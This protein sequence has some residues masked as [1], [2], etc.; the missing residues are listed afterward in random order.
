VAAIPAVREIRGQ[1]LAADGNGVEDIMGRLGVHTIP[2][3]AAEGDDRTA[4]FGYG[5]ATAKGSRF[6]LLRP[7]AR[8]HRPGWSGARY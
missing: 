7:H 6:L 2:T 3:E 5:V 8:G 4:S 1:L